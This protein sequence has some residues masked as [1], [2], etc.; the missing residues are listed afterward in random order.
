MGITLYNEDCY[1]T[2]KEKL[3]DSK[4]NIDI[5]LTSPPY[6]NSRPTHTE[7][8]RKTYQSRYDIYLDTMNSEDYCNWCVDLFNTFDKFLSTNG[9][10]LWNVSYNSSPTADFNNIGQ[11][12]IIISEIIKQTSF[13]V[14]DRIIWKKKSALPNNTSPNKLTR[15]VE[16]IFVFVRKDEYKTFITNKQCTKTSKTGQKYYE[17]IFNYIEA[18]NNDGSCPYNK[19]TFSSELVRKL[20]NIY[21]VPN[22]TVYDPFM[23]T[24]TTA[25]AC[26][27]MGLNC[28]GTELSKNQYEWSLERLK[29]I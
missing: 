6:N 23:G 3:I 25:V 17:N 11:L 21:A 2:M 15:I 9:V 20:L 8:S 13:T 24:G 29:N 26:K 16:D 22:S 14:A 27:Q 18:A 10:V 7:K 4:Q 28:I 19:A 5:I 12:W 1:K